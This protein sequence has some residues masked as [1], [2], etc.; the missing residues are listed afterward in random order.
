MKRWWILPAGVL[1]IITLLLSQTAMD[2]EDF[3][4]QWYSSREQCVYLFRDGLIYCEKYPLTVLE[5][6]AVS[7]AYTFSGKSV[8][9]FAAGIEGL[10]ESREL[11]LVETKEE[12]MLCE[13]KDGTGE[14]YFV[15]DNR[16]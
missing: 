13:H 5:D 9:L 3:T 16:K 4:G 7:G 14:I 12:S 6:A 10:E 1:L 15:R 11:Y 8:Y 2:P